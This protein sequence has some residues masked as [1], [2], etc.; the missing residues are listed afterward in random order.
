MGDLIDFQYS[1]PLDV[2]AQK[3][4]CFPLMGISPTKVLNGLSLSDSKLM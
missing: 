1:G 3:V 4:N 2:E